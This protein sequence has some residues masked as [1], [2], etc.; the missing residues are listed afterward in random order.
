MWKAE[1]GDLV[2]LLSFPFNCVVDDSPPLCPLAPGAGDF[3]V[4]LSVPAAGTAEPLHS[5]QEGDGPHG[6][7]PPQASPRARM[8]LHDVVNGA[9][10]ALPSTM[11][12]PNWKLAAGNALHGQRHMA[13]D[14]A[15][16]H[17]QRATAGGAGSESAFSRTDGSGFCST[18]QVRSR[19]QIYRSRM[20]FAESVGHFDYIFEVQLSLNF[21]N[22]V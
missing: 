4:S 18:T 14:E 5:A 11:S 9:P 10:T 13:A 21:Y 3:S 7:L 16:V 12:H 2:V 8:V 6:T 20:R 1:G 22:G 15:S 19:G 17:R